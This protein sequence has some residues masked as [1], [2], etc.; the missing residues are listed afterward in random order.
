[1]DQ[2]QTLTMHQQNEGSDALTLIFISLQ[3]LHCYGYEEWLYEILT[4][5]EIINVFLCSN[6]LNL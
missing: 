3:T 1:M 4:M 6:W 2:C 5:V